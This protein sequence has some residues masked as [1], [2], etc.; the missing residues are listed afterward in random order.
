MCYVPAM[1]KPDFIA[2]L[3]IHTAGNPDLNT[4]PGIDAHI[5]KV[6]KVAERFE[7]AGIIPWDRPVPKNVRDLRRRR[8]S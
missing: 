1:T 7:A 3:F 5:A 8:A 4:I 6:A 2:L